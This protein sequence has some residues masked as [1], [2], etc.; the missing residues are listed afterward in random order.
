MV[1]FET[2]AQE[3]VIVDTS[4]LPTCI[5]IT[6]FAF[7]VFK[8]VDSFIS[9]MYF[10]TRCRECLRKRAYMCVYEKCYYCV[11]KGDNLSA[12]LK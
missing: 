9:R 2:V 11:I 10:C 4:F 1:I 6:F 5:I 3:S 7:F 8:A 12:C